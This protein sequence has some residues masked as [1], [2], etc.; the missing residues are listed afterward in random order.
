LLE[1]SAETIGAAP[2]ANG[3]LHAPGSPAAAPY[4]RVP[5]AW[6]SFRADFARYERY[7]RPDV[8]WTPWERVRLFARTEGL[9]ALALYRF[10]RYVRNDAPQ[11]VRRALHVPLAVA[12]QTLRLGIGINLDPDAEIG[13]GL[14]IGHSG[15]IWVGPGAVL[16]RECN[17]AHNVTIGVGGTLRRGTPRLGDRVWIGPNATLSGPIRIGD[18]AVIG[19]NS[20]A[21]ADVPPRGVAVGVPA[22]LVAQSGSSALIG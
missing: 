20:L 1:S 16:G 18:E 11:A 19:A 7:Y 5:S 12:Q 14:Y 9:W 8:R 21:V 17:V 22:R 15:G 2:A 10:R 3:D 4:V 6:R 13:P